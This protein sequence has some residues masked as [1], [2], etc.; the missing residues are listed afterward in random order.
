[1]IKELFY[2]K[3]RP[4]KLY[5]YLSKVIEKFEL[6]EILD[7][8]TETDEINTALTLN[9][10]VNIIELEGFTKDED[11]EETIIDIPSNSVESVMLIDTLRHTENPDAV[12]KEAIRVSRR[13]II[14]KDTLYYGAVSYL[15]LR[16][17]D[18]FK[19]KALKTDSAHWYLNFEDWKHL[20]RDNDLRIIYQ[21]RA[22]E[23]HD[24][25]LKKLIHFNLHF[26]LVLEKKGN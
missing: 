17:M 3:L 18:K 15:I 23:L 13:Y 9:H 2:D 11:S 25:F 16:L 7:V 22:M 1:M 10:Q 8:G 26:L 4:Y 20:Y 24:N 6:R 21:R 5:E 19:D 14:L 12:L